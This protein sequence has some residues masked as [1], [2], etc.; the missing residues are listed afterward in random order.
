MKKKLIVLAVV[1]AVIVG[2]LA[3]YQYVP[4]WASIVSTGAFI[5]GIL[6][7][8]NAKEWSDKHVTGL[9]V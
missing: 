8:W 3:Y 1:V 4:F 2:L 9:K 5:A 7:G 6:L